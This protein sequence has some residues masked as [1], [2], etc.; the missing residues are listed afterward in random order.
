MIKS[1]KN[2]NF[3]FVTKQNKVTGYVPIVFNNTLIYLK[4]S[5][6]KILKNYKIFFAI[7]LIQWRSKG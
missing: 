5:R 3:I 1:I 6:K 7:F 4:E 2:K